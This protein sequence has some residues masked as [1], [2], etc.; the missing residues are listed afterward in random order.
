MRYVLGFARLSPVFFIAAS[1]S[2]T[3]R[4]DVTVQERTNF[5]FVLIKAHGTTTEMTTTDKQRR[6]TDFHCEGFMSLFCRNMES[7]EIIRL[8]RDV[9]WAL[10]PKKKE[11]QETPFP[12]A[13]QRQ[14]AEQQMQATLEKMKQC[15]AMQTTSTP[16]PDTSKC[17]MSAPKIDVK[18]TDQ[19]A[20]LVGHDARLTQLALTESCRN[21]ETGDTCDFVITLDSWLTQDE[22]AGAADRR[23]F[24]T[25]YLHKL[26]FD[27]SNPAL[28]KQ[29]RQFLAPYASSL[30]ELSAKAADFKG[31]PLKSA[32]R[33]SFGGEHCAAAK[34]GGAQG[35]AASAS[36]PVSS[37][38]EA[39]GDAAAS[40][41]ASAAGAE[42]ANA[43][44][45]AAGGGV[46]GSI[47]NSA[48]GTFGSK[49]VS[50]LFNKKHASPTSTSAQPTP[51][52]GPGMI[53]AGEFTI[54]TTSITSGAI[55]P[56][57]F[58]VPPGWKLVSPKAAPEKEFSCPKPGA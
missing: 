12:T 15:P 24:Q 9:S 53:Q 20:T 46:A 8:D 5:D 50:G 14:A 4:A 40:A 42:A 43:A 17:E 7:G 18:L 39:A 52:A 10:E 23:A 36:S 25:A 11:Y 44:G 26:G 29:V 49:L 35:M 27:E 38:G 47:L 28:Q 45:R 37:A 30:K 56:E 34:S 41:T 32:F 21:R 33:V 16:T 1:L 3:A 54:E 19:H 55:A 6:D 57:Q 58:D 22:V 31:Y 13:A 48:A 51:T 2:T